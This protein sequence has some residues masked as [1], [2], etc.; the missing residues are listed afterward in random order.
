MFFLK[1][2]FL[3]GVSINQIKFHKISRSTTTS[4]LLIDSI[5]L[6]VEYQTI[7]NNEQLFWCWL[8]PDANWK[9]LYIYCIYVFI[10]ADHICTGLSWRYKLNLWMYLSRNIFIKKTTHQK[11]CTMLLLNFFSTTITGSNF[12]GPY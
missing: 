4:K 9:C 6:E 7:W 1:V 12:L 8:L 2:V 5:Q 3:Q 11:T 10:R